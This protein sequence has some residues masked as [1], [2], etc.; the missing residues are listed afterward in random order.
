MSEDGTMYT[1]CLDAS[2]SEEVVEQAQ[3][4]R[5]ELLEKIFE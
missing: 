2:K 4:M 1:H 3:T 5:V